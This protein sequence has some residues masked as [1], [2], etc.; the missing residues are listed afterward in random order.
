[1]IFITLNAWK[2]NRNVQ[3]NKS[4]ISDKK[5][6]KYDKAWIISFIVFLIIHFFDIT[7]FD[8]R[9]STL[10]W[11]LLAGMRAMIKEGTNIKERSF[12][13]IS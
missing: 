13:K 6:N 9:I 4:S 12:N 10:S 3:L 2:K 7:Y 5:I 11:I 1:M 8:G